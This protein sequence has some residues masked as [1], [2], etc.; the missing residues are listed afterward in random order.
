MVPI[1]QP[2]DTLDTPALVLDLDALEHN[3]ARMAGIARNAGMLLRPQA[4][5]HKCAEIARRQVA[6]GAVGVCCQKLSEA[7][8]MV[9]GGVSDVLV[10]YPIVGAYKANRLAALA[11]HARVSAIADH[12]DQ[13]AAL[14]RAAREHGV[15]LTLLVDVYPGGMRGGVDPGAPAVTLA[16]LIAAT[17]GLTFG[18]LQAYNGS[19]QHVRDHDQR[20]QAFERYTAAVRDTR[21]QLLSA[22][23]RCASITGS[24]TGTY[25]WEAHSGVFTELQP[26]SYVFMDADYVLNQEHGAGSGNGFRHSLFVLT[27]VVHSARP[28][29][30]LVDAG[31]KALNTD[32]ARAWVW[33]QP[34]LVYTPTGDEQGRIDVPGGLAAPALGQQLLLVPGHCDPTVNL[35]AEIVAIRDS[36][37]EA[38]W[39]V[40]ARGA[41]T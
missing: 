25:A 15:T 2:L 31:V 29:Y 5:T 34:E 35:H 39:P 3:L 20:R 10:T 36:R 41:M 23:L 13:V 1:G 19:A 40:T 17:P 38:V 18:G 37:I 30:V 4:K 11:R 22:G 7:E 26:G 27:A 16:Q 28:G 8:A 6:L 14:G 33:G 32:P 9:Q 21:D 12:P 24:G